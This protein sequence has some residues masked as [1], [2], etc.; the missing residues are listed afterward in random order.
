MDKSVLNNF[1]SK[2]IATRWEPSIEKAIE[3]IDKNI[4]WWSR[5]QDIIEHAQEIFCMLAFISVFFDYKIFT[6]A[7]IA[8][9][10]GLNRAVTNSIKKQ[11]ELKSE[12]KSIYS[13]A[14]VDKFL[15]NTNEQDKDESQV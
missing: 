1:Q 7:S 15:P 3:R 11:S 8:I 13:D 14:G 10:G 5:Y 6:G 9:S 12:R 4:E 2:L